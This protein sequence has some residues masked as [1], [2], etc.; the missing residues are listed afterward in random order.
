MKG[1]YASSFDRDDPGLVPG[2]PHD[3]DDLECWES[4]KE[5]LDNYRGE[6]LAL[7]TRRPTTAIPVS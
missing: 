7:V 6:L 1:A 5:E 2:I 3:P 4:I